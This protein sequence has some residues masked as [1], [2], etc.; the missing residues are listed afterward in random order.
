MKTHPV[1]RKK[2]MRSLL[3]EGVGEILGTHAASSILTIQWGPYRKKQ[4]LF[5][6]LLVCWHPGVSR[7]GDWAN[8]ACEVVDPV[9]FLQTT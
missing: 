4:E 5:I 2:R 6:C 3:R 1:G 7:L 9:G 8:E